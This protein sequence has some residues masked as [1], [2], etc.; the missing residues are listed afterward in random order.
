M[1]ESTVEVVNGTAIRASHSDT[2]LTQSRR[3]TCVREG[4]KGG[5]PD[6]GRRRR[7]PMAAERAILLRA[8]LDDVYDLA[9]AIERWPS[10]APCY[11]S[12]RVR[13]E[14]GRR[15]LVEVAARRD[16]IPFHL[17]VVQECHPD[18]PE[19]TYRHV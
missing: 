6:S 19:I 3:G 13:G 2:R 18:V 17:L 9:R 16:W 4:G 11:Q 14:H 10:L 12:V 5:L 15:R 1:M 7:S 8:P